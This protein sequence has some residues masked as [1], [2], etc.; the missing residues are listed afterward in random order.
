MNLSSEEMTDECEVKI[1]T[2]TNENS[3]RLMIE[4]NGNEKTRK[5]VA[6]TLNQ[7]FNNPGGTYKLSIIV[8]G[9]T[10]RYHGGNFGIESS[11]GNLPKIF[12][13]LPLKGGR[14]Q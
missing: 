14:C 12:I 3:V 7:I 10:I 8:A 6:K 4:F 11:E 1:S 13:E 2:Q 5:K 9:E